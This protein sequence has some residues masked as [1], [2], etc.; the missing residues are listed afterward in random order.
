MAEF[1]KQDGEIGVL[2]N[3]ESARGPFFAGI[4]NGENVVVFQ[5]KNKKSPKAP[6][7]TILKS[8]PKDAPQEEAPAFTEDDF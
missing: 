6:D 5:N 1:K 8:K 4:V 3:R 7:W 2:W